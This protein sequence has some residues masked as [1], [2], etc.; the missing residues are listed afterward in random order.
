MFLM[1]IKFVIY[2]KIVNLKFSNVK[3]ATLIKICKEEDFINAFSVKLAISHQLGYVSNVQL[4]AILAMKAI[5][6]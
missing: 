5:Q 4:A 1:I 6:T 2:F 3:V